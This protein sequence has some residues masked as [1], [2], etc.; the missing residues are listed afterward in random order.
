MKMSLICMRM[1]SL[2]YV[3]GWAPRLALRKRPQ[4]FTKTSFYRPLKYKSLVRSIPLLFLLHS[5]LRTKYSRTY[6]YRCLYN[7]DTSF[8]TDIWSQRNQDSYNFYQC[9]TDTSVVRHW[10]FPVRIK[11]VPPGPGC[12]KGRW[13]TPSNG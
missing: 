8:I 3:K 13:L 10:H 1:K 12:L 11:D 9:I 2:F 5:A 7:K 6:P 4:L